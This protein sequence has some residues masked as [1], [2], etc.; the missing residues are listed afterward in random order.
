MEV[1]T[2]IAVEKEKFKPKAIH[3]L[4]RCLTEKFFALQRCIV[5]IKN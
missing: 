5:I 1:Y 2:M 4:Q 3:E